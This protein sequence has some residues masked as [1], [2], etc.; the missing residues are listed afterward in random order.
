MT[1]LAPPPPHLARLFSRLDAGDASDEHL[2][3]AFA[4]WRDKRGQRLMPT[5]DDVYPGPE[6]I[7]ADV[8]IFRCADPEHEWRATEAG[9]E[10][11]R[12]LGLDGADKSLSKLRAPRIAARL[13][14][15]FEMVGET[16]EPI[17]AAFELRAKQGRQWIEVLAAPL[18]SD[19]RR[20]DGVYGGI[21]RR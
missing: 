3:S 5:A 7:A 9:A 14:R 13:R 10:A 11:A 1:T 18:S 2:R 20:V 16:G 6:L 17:A 15:L 4:F 19:G 12:L 21:R 8:F